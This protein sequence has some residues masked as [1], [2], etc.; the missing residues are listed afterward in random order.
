MIVRLHH[1]QITIPSGEE[2][3]CRR[4][5]CDVLG[6]SEI[7][8]PASLQER[9]GFWLELDGIQIHVG[10][11]DNVDRNASKAH[12]AYQVDD[13]KS[14]RAKLLEKN[15]KVI[16]GIAI[17]GYERFEF[18]DPFGNRVEFLEQIECTSGV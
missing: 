5:Y 14:W 13:L 12:L 1:A 4:F 11:E 7:P 15:V 16:D 8:K 3:S 9:G 18:R 2:D 10:T 6:L 17:P